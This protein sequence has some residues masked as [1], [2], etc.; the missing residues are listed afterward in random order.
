LHSLQQLAD[1]AAAWQQQQQQRRLAER[2]SREPPAYFI[3]PI[4]AAVMKDPVVAADGFTYERSAVTR[5]LQQQAMRRSPMTNKP[6]ET[7]L[8]PNHS[9]RSSIMEW[10]QQQHV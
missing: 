4:T 10:R 8:V 2:S 6:M 3:C 5:W 7:L 9:L 1:Q